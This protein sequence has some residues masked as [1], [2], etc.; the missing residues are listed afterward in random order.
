MRAVSGDGIGVAAQPC[1]KL[2]DNSYVTLLI[3]E[4]V[5]ALVTPSRKRNASFCKG[6]C[7]V[8]QNNPAGSKHIRDRNNSHRIRRDFFRQNLDRSIVLFIRTFFTRYRTRKARAPRTNYAS[9]CCLKTN[10]HHWG[11]TSANKSSKASTVKLPSN[12]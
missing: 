8:M 5:L 4:V 12:S 2:I 7:R 11:K 9:Q 6:L 10:S 1:V 3:H